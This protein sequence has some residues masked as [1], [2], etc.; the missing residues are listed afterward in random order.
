MPRRRNSTFA[1]PNEVTNGD[2][3]R[4]PNLI[5]NY[6]KGLAHNGIGEVLP[7]S[8]ASLLRAVNNGDPRLFEQIQMGGKAPLV[9]PQAGSGV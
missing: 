8:Y 4:F 2:E 6:S 3:Q 1:S 5:G 9:D 7:A